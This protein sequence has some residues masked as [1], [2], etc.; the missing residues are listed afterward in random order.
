MYCVH[1]IL[2]NNIT[3]VIFRLDG[4]ILAS[5]DIDSW[6]K[7]NK[8]YQDLFYLFYFINCSNII[9][10]GL[11]QII[12]FGYDWWVSTFT[13]KHDLF[14]ITRPILI[15]TLKSQNF[16]FENFTMWDAP[17]YNID[18]HN[19]DNFEFRNMFILV[20]TTKQRELFLIFDNITLYSTQSLPMFPLN[21]D[22]IDPSGKNYYIHNCTIKNFDD[23]VAVKPG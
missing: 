13:G 5:K 16:L 17:Y 4:D 18:T 2:I 19:S 12:G 10:T 11:G 22:G 15:K 21:T 20:N 14:N 6:P 1:P 7:N 9:W 3:K 8:N 23:A